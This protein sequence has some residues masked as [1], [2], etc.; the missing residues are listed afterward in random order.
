MSFDGADHHAL[1]SAVREFLLKDVVPGLPDKGLA[2]R[3]R[4]AANLIRIAIGEQIAGDPPTPGQEATDE[5]L[6]AAL[7]HKLTVVN[8]RFDLSEDL[9]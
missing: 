6:V 7:R 5:E 4:I 8:P 1:V 9:D 2:F 3:V